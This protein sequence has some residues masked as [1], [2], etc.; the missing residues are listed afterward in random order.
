VVSLARI[1]AAFAAVAAV[2]AVSDAVASQSVDP[3]RAGLAYAKC[4]RAHGVPHP[5]PDRKGN[6][7]LTPAQ[8]Q[9]LRRVGRAKVEAADKACFK[10]LRPVVSTKPLSAWAKAQAVKVLVQL[11]SCVRGFGF[12]MGTPFVK[13]LSRGRAKFGFKPTATDSP[14]SQ[15]LRKAQHICERRVQ[16]AKKITAIIAADRA[17]L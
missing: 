7:T 1:I 10:Y 4:M 3:Y 14:P 2:A 16:L 12:K 8:E 17:P 15:E 9:R 13:N 6:F 11:R 5:N